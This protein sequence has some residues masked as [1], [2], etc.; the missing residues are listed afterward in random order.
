[1]CKSGVFMKNTKIIAVSE[2]GGVG[3]TSVSSAFVRLLAENY[4]QSD[5]LAI[6]ADPAT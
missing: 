4:P 6:N 5:I 1:M 2:K 3:K